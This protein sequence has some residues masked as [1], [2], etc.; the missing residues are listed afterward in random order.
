MR[1][2]DYDDIPSTKFG[3]NKISHSKEQKQSYFDHKQTHCDI[4][5]EVSIPIFHTTLQLMMMYHHTQFGH[6]RFSGSEDIIW[7]NLHQHLET[8]L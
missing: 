7:T 3:C 1:S 8:Q 6:K 2:Q 5:L 4:D